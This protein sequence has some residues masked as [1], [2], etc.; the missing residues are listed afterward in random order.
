MYYWTS[1]LVLARRVRHPRSTNVI[2]VIVFLLPCHHLVHAL[3][4]RSTPTHDRNGHTWDLQCFVK[5]EPTSS[6]QSAWQAG[7]LP[8]GWK[9]QRHIMQF[10][11]LS[12]TLILHIPMD[13]ALTMGNVIHSPS[14]TN[15]CYASL[16]HWF[17]SMT[18]V[19][20]F[21]LP[22]Y[23]I[24]NALYIS[25]TLA[26]HINKIAAIYSSPMFL[27]S[28]TLVYVPVFESF[29][30]HV[31]SV[32]HADVWFKLPVWCCRGSRTAYITSSCMHVISI[33]PPGV[34]L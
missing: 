5:T 31:C 11:K 13:L 32:P 10:A 8:N 26:S 24:V 1:L 7:S 34:Y 33:R 21:R 28:H 14:C 12:G 27:H 17:R 19:T 2:T 15:W 25:C 23:R 29:G 4:G 3:C 22:V 20:D 6:M 30:L 9:T 18:R 16:F